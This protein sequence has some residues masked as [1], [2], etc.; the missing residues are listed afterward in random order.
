M[1]SDQ[2]VHYSGYLQLDNILNAQQP[3]SHKPGVTPA[4]DEMLFIIIHQAYELWFKQIIW[5]LESVITILSKPTLNDNT[6]DLQTIVHRL[7]RVNSI[8][9]LLVHQMDVMETMTPMDFLEFRDLL[10]P[11]S[12]FQSWQFKKIEALLGLRFEGRHAQHYYTSQLNAGELETVKNA[13]RSSSLTE[14]VNRWLERMPFMEDPAFGQPDNDSGKGSKISPFWNL[15]ADVYNSTL[16]DAEKE[17][18]AAFQRI[19][20]EEIPDSNRHFSPKACRAALFIML[21]RGYPVLQQ[22]FQ[23]LELLLETD[24]ELANWRFRHYGMVQKMI[25]TRIGTGG[26]TGGEYLKGAMDKHYIFRELAQLSSFLIDRSRLPDL[27][28][29]LTGK[30]GYHF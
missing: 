27:P 23:L 4:H 30:L 15:Y 2:P 17:N 16:A 18:A 14:L 11:A 6:S 9:K 26:S 12:G 21:Y 22:P 25:G 1:Q 7:S 3:E 19:F 10:R 20:E 29:A 13:E 24:N 8:L 5:E 28:T